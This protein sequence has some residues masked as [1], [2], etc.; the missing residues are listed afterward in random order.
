MSKS[1]MQSNKECYVTG[2]EYNLHKHHIFGGANR[3]LSERYG[4]WVYLRADY[5][6]MSNYGVHFDK[7]FD[8]RLKSEAQGAAMNKHG[9][10]IEDFIHIFGKNYL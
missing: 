9:W 4:L 3:K 10:S 2:E 6:N 7:D 5:H 1:I 8:L